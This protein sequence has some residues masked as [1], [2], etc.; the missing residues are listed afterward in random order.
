V[1]GAFFEKTST[2]R[3]V[4]PH[5]RPLLRLSVTAAIAV[6]SMAATTFANMSRPLFF[7]YTC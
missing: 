1:Y 4:Q 6:C 2:K 3:F 7:F 5:R